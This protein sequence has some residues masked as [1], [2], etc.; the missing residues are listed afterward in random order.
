MN[1]TLI[2]IVVIIL[3]LSALVLGYLFFSQDLDQSL[4]SVTVTTAS[5]LAGG[6]STLGFVGLL[7]ELERINLNTA[8]L[9]SISGGASATLP[10]VNQVRQG[11]NNPFSA[12]GS[13][14][15]VG[16]EE[17]EEEDEEEMI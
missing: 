6:E 9:G 7:T 15:E 3:I 11:R 10:E 14:G 12:L 4:P 17:I 16:Q 13:L 2:N 5:D 8:V 1:N